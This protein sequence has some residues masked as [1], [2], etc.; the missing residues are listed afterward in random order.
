MSKQ[1]VWAIEQ[2]SYS[3]YHIVG[4]FSSRENAQRVIDA[5][6]EERHE[7]PSLVEWD[8]DPAVDEL[9]QGLRIFHVLMR[10]DGTVEKCKQREF[11]TYNLDEE[12]WVWKRSEARAYQGT[13]EAVD[14]LN[15]SV[16]ARDTEHAIKIVN[17]VRAQWIAEGK[18]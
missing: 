12:H 10:K 5:L 4:V 2:G 1:K 8:L 17:E 13:P 18:F 9:N 15:S 7:P 6:P 16:W 3:D 11:G 14:V